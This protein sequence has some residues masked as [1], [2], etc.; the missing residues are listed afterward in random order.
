MKVPKAAPG[1]MVLIAPSPTEQAGVLSR[2]Y[3]KILEEGS[4]WLRVDPKPLFE[5]ITAAG[6]IEGFDWPGLSHKPIL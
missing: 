5:P 4:D 2:Y 1:L 6:R 3:G